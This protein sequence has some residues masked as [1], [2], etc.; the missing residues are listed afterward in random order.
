M[1]FSGKKQTGFQRYGFRVLTVLFWLAFLFLFRIALTPVAWL[2]SAES[3]YE[4]FALK[5]ESQDFLDLMVIYVCVVILIGVALI[6]WARY[7]QARFRQNERR[8]KFRP[9]V[10]S[11]EVATFY[12]IPESL[13]LVSSQARRLV[14]QHDEKGRVEE[15]ATT[16]RLPEL[17]PEPVPCELNSFTYRGYLL[18]RNQHYRWSVYL[19]GQQIFFGTDFNSVRDYVDALLT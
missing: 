19:D 17:P 9:P 6:G 11:H 16:G 4:M 3:V 7:N 8:T 2:V 5:V 13:L 12:Q 1:I 14:I 18:K 10:E 15:I